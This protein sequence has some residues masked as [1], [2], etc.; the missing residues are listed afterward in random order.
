MVN[1]S[2]SSLLRFALFTT[3]FALVMPLIA[4]RLILRVNFF[5]TVYFFAIV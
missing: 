1:L 2:W 3:V 5:S 4:L